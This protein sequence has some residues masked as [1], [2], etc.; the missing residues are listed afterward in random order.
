MAEQRHMQ[1]RGKDRHEQGEEAPSG[2][3]PGAGHEQPKPAEDLRDPRDRIER[4]QPGEPRGHH[5][6]VRLGHAKMIGAGHDEKER[7]DPATHGDRAR[8][9]H[10]PN[11]GR[12]GPG[13]NFPR[14]FMAADCVLPT[15]PLDRHFRRR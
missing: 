9:G 8:R 4:P 15:T 12:L 11:V 1:I 13:R 10:G 6:Q 2:E 3:A 5:A 14:I 7:E